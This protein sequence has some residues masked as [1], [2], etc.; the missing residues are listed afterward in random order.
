MVTSVG[1]NRNG[2][3]VIKKNGKCKFLMIHR[4]DFV[5]DK[6]DYI[7]I[8]I[9]V[10]WSMRECNGNCVKAS[11]SGIRT[12]QVD[13]EVKLVYLLPWV[14][15][16]V[17]IWSVWCVNFLVNMWLESRWW[18]PLTQFIQKKKKKN[19]L[20]HKRVMHAKDI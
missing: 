20:T 11:K 9:C 19:P 7:P 2:K 17:H 6:S 5:I 18:N 8:S 14:H 16:W 1:I 13:W 3:L 4:S 10:H 12:R 15:P